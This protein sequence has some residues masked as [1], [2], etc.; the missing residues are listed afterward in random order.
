MLGVM[1]A[2]ATAHVD[3]RH[4][5][6]ICGRVAKQKLG[7]YS[8]MF[9]MNASDDS[10]HRTWAYQVTRYTIS[11]SGMAKRA[12]IKSWCLYRVGVGANSRRAIREAGP[13]VEELT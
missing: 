7:F 11:R 13:R 8:F 1:E 4:L 5:Y 9:I 12:K 3:G 10:R 6:G 2:M